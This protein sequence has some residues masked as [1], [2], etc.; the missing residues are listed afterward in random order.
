MVNIIADALHLLIDISIIRNALRNIAALLLMHISDNLIEIKCQLG[1]PSVSSVVF[2][3]HI[4]WTNILTRNCPEKLLRYICGFSCEEGHEG[5]DGKSNFSCYSEFINKY[6]VVTSGQWSSHDSVPSNNECAACDF[7]SVKNEQ[8][9]VD[10]LT[11]KKIARSLDNIVKHYLSVFVLHFSSRCISSRIRFI[12][13]FIFFKTSFATIPNPFLTSPNSSSSFSCIW[14]H[15]C[16][17]SAFNRFTC[18]HQFGCGSVLKK[19]T[20]SQIY[21]CKSKPYKYTSF[22][23]SN[24]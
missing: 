17:Y 5:K 14:F 11:T 8:L 3:V 22:L 1:V 10:A 12:F 16:Y 4:C 2:K 24:T 13:N 23:P 15:D 9:E 18:F 21:K 19:L 7:R 20:Y 6:I